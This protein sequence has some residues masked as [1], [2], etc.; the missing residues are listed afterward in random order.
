MCICE[1]QFQVSGASAHSKD[2]VILEYNQLGEYL[3]GNEKASE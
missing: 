1:Q 3:G 2:K